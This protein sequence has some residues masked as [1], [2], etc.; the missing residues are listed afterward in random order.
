MPARRQGAKSSLEFGDDL[1][2]S[3]FKGHSYAGWRRALDAALLFD[4][5]R[6]AQAGQGRAAGIAGEFSGP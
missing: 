1:S 3:R 2:F 5:K 4:R 6:K